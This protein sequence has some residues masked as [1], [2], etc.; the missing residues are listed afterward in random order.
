MFFLKISFIFHYL[1][2][3]IIDRFFVE[4]FIQFFSILFDIHHFQFLKYLNLSQMTF[5]FLIIVYLLFLSNLHLNIFFI[6]ILS[7]WFYLLLF[8][9]LLIFHYIFINFTSYY[10]NKIS[11]YFI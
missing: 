6:N 11:F 3:M 8:T 2:H 7:L 4:I 9:F 10:L 5:P 1:M